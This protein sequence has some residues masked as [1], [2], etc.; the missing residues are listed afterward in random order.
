MADCTIKCLCKLQL[1]KD[2]ILQRSL[3]GAKIKLGSIKQR[4]SHSAAFDHLIKSNKNQIKVIGLGAVN[5]T[6]NDEEV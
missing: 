4:F 2:D 6:I 3:C 5:T 1:H